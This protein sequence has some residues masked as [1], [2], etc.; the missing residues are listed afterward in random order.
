MLKKKVCILGSFSVGKTSLVR[1]FV[2]NTFS[3][4]YLTTVGVKVEQ[5][6]VRSNEKDLTLVVWDIHG[7]DVYQR[8][9]KSYLRGAAGYF[10]VVDGTREQ[11][12]EVALEIRQRFSEQLSDIPGIFLVN[13]FDLKDNWR[14]GTVEFEKMESLGMPLLKTSAMTGEKVEESF[15]LLSEMMLSNG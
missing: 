11:S 10:L 9:Q 7:D 8:L 6:L 2:S 3:D 15:R 5:K 1:R 13:K 4:D 14:L 12:F